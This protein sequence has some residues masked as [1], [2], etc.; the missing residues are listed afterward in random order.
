MALA[1]PGDLL[2]RFTTRAVAHQDVFGIVAWG[3]QD[4]G[5]VYVFL[6]DL[7]SG[8][9]DFSAIEV[10]ELSLCLAGQLISCYRS[11]PPRTTACTPTP[12]A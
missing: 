5:C 2:Q 9:H 10:L 12:Q 11:I 3:T 6:G 4:V 8:V 1:G 7:E